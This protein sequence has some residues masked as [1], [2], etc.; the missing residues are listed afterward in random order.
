LSRATR[1]EGVFLTDLDFDAIK[2][3]PE[4]IA[5]YERLE[6]KAADFRQARNRV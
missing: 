1:L 4:A 2:A 6:A 5:E 3:D